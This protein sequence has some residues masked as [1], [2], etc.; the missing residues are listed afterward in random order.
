MDLVNLFTNP[1]WLGF[2]IGLPLAMV[3]LIGW[4]TSGGYAGEV[5]SYDYYGLAIMV[6]MAL[7]AA[8]TAANSF[9][10]ERIKRPNL[11]IVHSPVPPWFI[12]FSKVLSTFVFCSACYALVALACHLVGGV[13][14]GG[15]LCWAVGLVM[16]LA[17]WACSALGV[18][19]CCLLHSESS[20]NQV[21]SLL[22]SVGSALGG[23]FFP[24]DGLGKA[25]SAVSWASPAKWLLRSCLRIIYDGD[26][27]LLAPTSAF[28]A[29]LS[30]LF[31]LVSARAFKEEDYL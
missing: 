17:I 31:A 22:I 29:A 19:V 24:V 8:T 2:A 12:H 16:E 23:V 21:L 11:R 4:L 1:M 25:I 28:L 5:S 3:A 30:A 14:Y 18:A 10:E 20:A 9:M 26:L 6:Y 27:A 7:N 15:G 13:N